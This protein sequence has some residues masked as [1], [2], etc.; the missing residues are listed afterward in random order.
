MKRL[1]MGCGAAAW[2]AWGVSGAAITAQPGADGTISIPVA[3]PG[4]YKLELK[5]RAGEGVPGRNII[6]RSAFG[7]R[8]LIAPNSRE[9]G[10]VED[11]AAIGDFC[12]RVE[13]RTRRPGIELGGATLTRVKELHLPRQHYVARPEPNRDRTSTRRPSA[14]RLW[15]GRRSTRCCTNRWR[16]TGKA[17][18]GELP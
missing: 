11:Y 13:I 2:L 1:L 16:R 5:A 17:R 12:D 15:R 4:I 6:L 7:D 8:V 9:W 10:T 14:G 18:S 3:E